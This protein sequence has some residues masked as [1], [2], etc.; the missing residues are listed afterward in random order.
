MD[1]PELP[2]EAQDIL[3]SANV[4]KT[5][6]GDGHI[7]WRTWGAGA[8]LI[9]LHGGSGSWMHWLRNIPAIAASGR[10]ACVPDLPGFGDSALPQGAKDADDL[11]E[12]LAQSMRELL[13][14]G[15]LEIVAFSF[16]SL[17]AVLLA[18]QYP[19]LVSR[20]VLVGAPVLP[21]PSGKGVQMR[22]WAHLP[23]QEERDDAHRYN[24]GA[25][26]L[27]RPASIDPVAVRIQ[28]LNLPRDRLPRRRLVTTSAFADAMARLKCR[29]AVVYGAEDALYRAWWPQVLAMFSDRPLCDGVTLIPDAGH[30]VQ[31]EEPRRFNDEL[32]Q[33]LSVR[34]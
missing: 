29:F 3:E 31:Y 22:H 1:A 15:P 30:W 4:R 6:C 25:L 14:E 13:G 34:R 26:M 11:F 9:M 18:A 16:G 21:L 27:H 23:T 33:V 2:R 19:Q 28:A 24:L 17:V 8:P 7:V 20:L 12:P 32:L 5:P 10:M